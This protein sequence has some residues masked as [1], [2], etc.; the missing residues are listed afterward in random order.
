M[1][2][3]VSLCACKLP[4]YEDKAHNH[5]AKL[6]INAVDTLHKH[7]D[8]RNYVEETLQVWPWGV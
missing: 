6:H 1:S 3:Q 8:G 7:K 4:K 2:I 5:N